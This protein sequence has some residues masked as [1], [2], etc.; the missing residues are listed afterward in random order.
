MVKCGRLVRASHRRSA[1]T[2]QPPPSGIAHPYPY[3]YAGQL[4]LTADRKGLTADP[5][6]CRFSWQLSRFFCSSPGLQAYDI[7]SDLRCELPAGAAKV[8]SFGGGENTRHTHSRCLRTPISDA[9]P[10][11][12][13]GGGENTRH[14]HSRCLRTPISDALSPRA[15]LI[16]QPRLGKPWQALARGQGLKRWHAGSVQTGGW[17]SL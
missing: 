8:A 11:A 12:S 16:G 14:T 2:R 4:R 10:L 7:L 17:A 5:I 15:H 9:L 1:P 13:F 6:V 3:P